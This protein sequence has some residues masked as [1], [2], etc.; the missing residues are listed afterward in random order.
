MLRHVFFFVTLSIFILEFHRTVSFKTMQQLRKEI[1]KVEKEE[2]SSSDKLVGKAMDFIYSNRTVM[3]L[4]ARELW[5]I[6]SRAIDKIVA[7]KGKQQLQ[8]VK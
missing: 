8:H 2:F 1:Q 6:G 4:I 7:V 3:S 5:D